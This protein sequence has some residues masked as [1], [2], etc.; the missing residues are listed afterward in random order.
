MHWDEAID[1]FVFYLKV[2]RRASRHTV[3]AYHRIVSRFCAFLDSDKEG[4]HKDDLAKVSRQD[5]E[6]FL[7]KL[8]LLGL[9]NRSL[10][11]TVVGLR[12]FFRFLLQE[13]I[14]SV[15]PT[16]DLDIP[17]FRPK[18]PVVLSESE[19]EAL[20]RAPSD[21]TAEGLRD[22]AILELLYGS[23]LRISEVL[24]LEVQNV[25]LVEGF[26]LVRGKGN[27][28]RV[29]PISDYCKDA[30]L[31]YLREGRPVLLKKRVLHRNPLFVTARGTVLTRQGF[32]K[33]M[34]K[35]GI[36]ANLARRVS[37]HKLR[38]SFATHLVE[39]GADLRS[40]QELLGH[41]DISTTEIYTH[42]S[43]RRLRKVYEKAHPRA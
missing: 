19:V 8:K 33:N 17:K 30:L 28:E 14:I 5:C 2:Q 37:P 10:A 26:V 12:Q 35:Y 42:V 43:R 40:V 18:L 27:K 29:V 20:L 32:Y 4:P 1:R 11:Q 39:N 3:S 7:E 15:D 31:R 21:D 25:N 24:S 36:L 9:S 22:R 34:R 6:R 23:G 38:H 16:E 13:R 41:A